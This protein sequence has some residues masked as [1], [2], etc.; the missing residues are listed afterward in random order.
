MTGP[1]EA[2]FKRRRRR[3]RMVAEK[4]RPAG[5]K[6]STRAQAQAPSFMTGPS[7]AW[8]KWRRRRPRMVAEKLR[9]AGRSSSQ[10]LAPQRRPQGEAGVAVRQAGSPGLAPEAG[11][12]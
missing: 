7:E 2:W 11:T 10:Q 1:S 12:A 8:F 5:R 3:P 6:S 4:L 9:L